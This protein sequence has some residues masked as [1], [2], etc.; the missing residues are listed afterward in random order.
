MM[1]EGFGFHMGYTV[2][3]E[4]AMADYDL[5]RGTDALKLFEKGKGARVVAP[6]PGDGYLGELGYMLDC[7]EQKRAPRRVTA[8]DGLSAVEIC[9]AEEQSI[10]TGQVVALA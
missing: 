1:G 7:I 4:G 6:E 8:Q 3:F 5:G 2:I 9:E 10:R